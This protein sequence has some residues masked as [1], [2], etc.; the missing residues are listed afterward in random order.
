MKKL[1]TLLLGLLL[2]TTAAQ[3]QVGVNVNLKS[4][5]S[6]GPAGYS[7]ATYYYLPDVETYYDVNRQQYVYLSNSKWIR[8]SNL[9]AAHRGYNLYNGYKVVFTN[10][11]PYKY[12]NTHKV[13]YKK[14]YKGKPQRTIGNNG[15]NGR[16]NGKVGT[17]GYKGP[18]KTSIKSSYIKSSS[19]KSTATRSTVVKSSEGKG[20]GKKD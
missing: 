3:A 16:G 1:T 4:A 7:N 18:K 2:A 20:K 17:P 11:E 6:W 19:G 12:F 9:P 13:K 15:N 8:S 10:P 14:G 5:P